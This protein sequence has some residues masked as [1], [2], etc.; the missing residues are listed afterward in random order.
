MLH[1]LAFFLK[2]LCGLVKGRFM[3]SRSIFFAEE[4]SPC[5]AISSAFISQNPPSR[6]AGSMSALIWLIASLAFSSRFVSRYLSDASILSFAA[7]CPFALIACCIR[8]SAD[9]AVFM[10]GFLATLCS[11][12]I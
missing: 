12:V 9:I 11:V 4:P 2:I 10:A 1:I 8:V 6:S 7:F 5:N 3:A